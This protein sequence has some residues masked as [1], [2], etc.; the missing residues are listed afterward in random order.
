MPVVMLVADWGT[1]EEGLRP[2]AGSHMVGEPVPIL[3]PVRN[4]G[5]GAAFDIQADLLF[6]DV[7]GDPSPAGQPNQISPLS[8]G[9]LGA[10]QA[11]V[12]QGSYGSSLASPLLSIRITLT[13]QDVF[14]AA[15]SSS[16][17]YVDRD[18]GFRDVVYNPPTELD[19]AR[20]GM[21][22]PVR[23][24]ERKR[25]RLTGADEA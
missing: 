5:A 19:P 8:Y 16:A 1:D 13:Y 18:R 25:L 21:T 10:D 14:G 24:S 6:G 22:P 3:V 17:T 2:R 11:T 9:A 23:S 15:Y 12:L 20:H 4:V 7:A